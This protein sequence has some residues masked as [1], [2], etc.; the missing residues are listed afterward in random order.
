MI[1]VDENINCRSWEEVM[2]A[3][4]TK[5]DPSRDATIIDNTPIDYLDFASPE[6]GL[7]GKIGID[8][9]DKIYPETSRTWGTP[10]KMTEDIIKMVDKKWK[11]YNID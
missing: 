8:A 3:I 4:S 10:I 11:K 1:V 2:W 9:T 5:F 7:G 6:N